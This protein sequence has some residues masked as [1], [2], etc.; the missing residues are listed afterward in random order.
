MEKFLQRHKRLQVLVK[1]LLWFPIPIPLMNSGLNCLTIRNLVQSPLSE[2]LLTEIIIEVEVSKA[3]LSVAD[4]AR[5]RESN[6][7]CQ[8]GEQTSGSAPFPNLS[9]GGT[10]GLAGGCCSTGCLTCCG[11]NACCSGPHNCIGG[12]CT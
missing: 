10:V 1:K 6:A 8:F 4:V 9:S 3:N 7:N 12:C 5:A 11:A 2:G